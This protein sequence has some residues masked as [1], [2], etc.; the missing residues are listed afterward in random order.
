MIVYVQLQHNKA[1]INTF[2]EGQ[3]KVTEP[4]GSK[5]G[6]NDQQRSGAIKISY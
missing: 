1:K 4:C 6:C 5:A 3:K 2:Q